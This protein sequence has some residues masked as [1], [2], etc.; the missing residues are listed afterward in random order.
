LFRPPWVTSLPGSAMNSNSTAFFPLA[1]CRDDMQARAARCRSLDGG[2]RGQT[3]VFSNADVITGAAFLRNQSIPSSATF[4]CG[5]A[6]IEIVTHFSSHSAFSSLWHAFMQQFGPLLFG[7]SFSDLPD[8]RNK[9]VVLQVHLLH[10]SPPNDMQLQ[11]PSA[12]QP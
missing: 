9:V 8:F 3:T 1:R 7:W 6:N 5:G 4:I 12:Q 11:R 2:W 10:S